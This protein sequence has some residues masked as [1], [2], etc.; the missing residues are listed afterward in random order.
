MLFGW[1]L[2]WLIANG[3]SLDRH[4]LCGNPA[5]LR[6]RLVVLFAALVGLLD[7][8]SVGWLVGCL[9]LFGW[10]LMVVC[11]L[12]CWMVANGWSLDRHRLCGNPPLLVDTLDKVGCFVCC[13]GC[14]VEW[15]VGWLPMVVCLLDCWLVANGWSLESLIS[16]VDNGNLPFLVDRIKLS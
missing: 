8:W 10:L 16:C 15:S 2:G 5:L 1:S 9:W 14:V 4:R 13:F 3:W 11:L 6:I 12:D 7:G